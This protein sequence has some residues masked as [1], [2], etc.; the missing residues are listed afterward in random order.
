MRYLVEMCECNDLVLSL[1]KSD[2]KVVINKKTISRPNRS[3]ES[4]SFCMNLLSK[5]GRLNGLPKVHKTRFNV[6]FP[7]VLSTMGTHNHE[8]AKIKVSLLSGFCSSEYTIKD[9]FS[10]ASLIGN[11]RNNNSYMAS[12]DVTSL[13]S[14]IPI[15]ETVTIILNRLFTDA[16]T[17]CGFTSAQFKNFGTLY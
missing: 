6:P 16:E 11:L 15:N 10:F 2:S 5:P 13:L 4:A 17:Y 12:F 14:N 1:Q 3:L 7:P 8:L 9:S